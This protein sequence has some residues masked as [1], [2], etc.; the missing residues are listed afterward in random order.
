LNKWSLERP[1]TRWQ[2]QL[3]EDIKKKGMEEQWTQQW[4]STRAEKNG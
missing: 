1:S 2:E 4:H 3:A